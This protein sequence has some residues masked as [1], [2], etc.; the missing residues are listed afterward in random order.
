MLKDKRTHLCLRFLVCLLQNQRIKKRK[1]FTTQENLTPDQTQFIVT[2]KV[3]I[4]Q[5]E[6]SINAQR[7]A[8]A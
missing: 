2:A 7:T 6:C 3:L 4:Q 1:K 8:A 5:L